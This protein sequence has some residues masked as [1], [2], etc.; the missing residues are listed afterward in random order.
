MNSQVT[1][2]KTRVKRVNARVTRLKARVGISKALP[3]TKKSQ[4]K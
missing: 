1:S 2:L 3:E 4:V